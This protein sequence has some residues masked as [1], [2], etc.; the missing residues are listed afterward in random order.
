VDAL[1]ASFPQLVVADLLIRTTFQGTFCQNASGMLKN[2]R[3]NIATAIWQTCN[4]QQLNVF[5]SP[6]TMLGQ[7]KLQG[8][9]T[10]INNEVNYQRKTE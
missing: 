5:L 8:I 1:A 10:W 7:R 3:I 2:T 4:L 9:K 6:L